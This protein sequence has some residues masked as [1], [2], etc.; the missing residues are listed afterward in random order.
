MLYDAPTYSSYLLF[1][2]TLFWRPLFLTFPFSLEKAVSSSSPSYSFVH[3]PSSDKRENQQGVTRRCWRNCCQRLRARR[4]S[5]PPLPYPRWIGSMR[6]F[7]PFIPNSLFIFPVPGFNC[8]C[9][10]DPS[11]VIY[12]LQYYYFV[13]K[14]QYY[15]ILLLFLAR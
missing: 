2:R 10:C 7:I 1:S 3:R 6:S 12:Q 11:I 5:L 13:Q 14:R 9:A 8:C 15:Y 4:R